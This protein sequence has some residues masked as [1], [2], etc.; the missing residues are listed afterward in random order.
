MAPF[1]K[2]DKILMKILYECEGDIIYQHITQ[3]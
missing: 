1:S 3:M 2:E